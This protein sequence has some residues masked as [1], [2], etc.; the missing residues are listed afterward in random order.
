[1]DE[2]KFKL[3][4]LE[5][6]EIDTAKKLVEEAFLVHYRDNMSRYVEE[7]FSALDTEIEITPKTVFTLTIK[8]EMPAGFLFQLGEMFLKQRN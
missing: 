3:S 6:E 7:A 2:L 1:M 4:D 8:S 5:N